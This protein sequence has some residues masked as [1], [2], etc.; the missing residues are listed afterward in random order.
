MTQSL[1]STASGYFNFKFNPED[2]LYSDVDRPGDEGIFDLAEIYY[3]YF[4]NDKRRWDNEE[5][6]DCHDPYWHG[7]YYY[8]A[9]FRPTI[10]QEQPDYAT[11]YYS[12][13]DWEDLEMEQEMEQEYYR[14]RTGT[15]N[16][17]YLATK[18][19]EKIKAIE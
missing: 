5:E 7:P 9:G 13:D 15:D 17:E 19:L 8:P 14:S 10:H 1:N 4:L 6:W 16:W 2:N 12:A 18:V 3:D 11:D